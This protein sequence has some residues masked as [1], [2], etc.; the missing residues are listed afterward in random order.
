[1][2]ESKVKKILEKG[3]PIPVVD[4]VHRLI[5][6]A[7]MRRASDIH[8]DPAEQSLRVRFRVDGM[9]EDAYSLPKSI[10]SEVISRIKILTS[11]R[12]DEHQTAQDGRFRVVIDVIGP[13]DV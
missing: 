13:I 12:T 11:L 8:L 10:T 4:L 7:Y 1:M 6:E 5:E 9:L 3:G 2:P